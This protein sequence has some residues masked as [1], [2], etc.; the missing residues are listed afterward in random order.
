MPS[1]HQNRSSNTNI[2]PTKKNATAVKLTMST[3]KGA[4]WLEITLPIVTVSE[5]NGGKKKT[6]R[7]G[8]KKIYKA[9]HWSDKHSRHKKQKG[10][11]VLMLNPHKKM[12]R[13]PCHITLTR[14]APNKLDRHDNLP[15]SMKW[16]L[17]SV[18]A[19]VTRDFRPGRA[20][21][22]ERITVS[23]AQFIHSEYGVKIH[24]NF[25]HT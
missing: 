10:A 19:M 8:G 7:R 23:Y 13:L 11:V 1:L 17:D 6:I 21:D 9:E 2:L 16:I 15:M 3:Q 24:L 12:F 5:A 4:D 18:C 22:D 20:D 14:Y 25:N